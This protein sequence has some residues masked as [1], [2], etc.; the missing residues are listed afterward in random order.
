MEGRE[1]GGQLPQVFP[2]TC[3][4]YDTANVPLSQAAPEPLVVLRE[5]SQHNTKASPQEAGLIHQVSEV[6]AG[7]AQA[8]FVLP[9][10]E[11]EHLQPQLIWKRQRWHHQAKSASTTQ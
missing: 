9:G 1:P 4:H 10:Q 8:Q 5:V 3:T 11:A 7:A 2:F 6:S